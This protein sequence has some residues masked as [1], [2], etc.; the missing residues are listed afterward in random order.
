[1]LVQLITDNHIAGREGLAAQVEAS[2]RGALE[3]FA[4]QIT[5]VEVHLSDTNAHKG[6]EHDKRCAMEARLAGLQPISVTETSSTVDGAVDGALD[7][8]VKILDKTTD[9]LN[10]HKGRTS[11]G[12]DQT[13]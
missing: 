3:R 2:V 9:K 7:K 12:G 11:F 6:G 4:Q 10:E 1:M 8:L 13:I 5:R